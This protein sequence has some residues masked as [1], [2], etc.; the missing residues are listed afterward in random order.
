MEQKS[1]DHHPGRWHWRVADC[2]TRTPLAAAQSPATSSLLLFLLSC[3]CCCCCARTDWQSWKNWSAHA[4]QV[5][6]IFCCPIHSSV[7]ATSGRRVRQLAKKFIQI[8]NSSETMSSEVRAV[9]HSGLCASLPLRSEV[10]SGWSDCRAHFHER[11]SVIGPR[12]DWTCPGDVKICPVGEQLLGSPPDGQHKV[13]F[14]RCVGKSFIAGNNVLILSRVF[15]EKT[16][17]F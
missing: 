1:N 15:G 9:P 11:R 16:K 6:A 17:W 4:I 2:E 5:L 7:P 10:R 13:Y 12:V 3:C 14:I 8:N